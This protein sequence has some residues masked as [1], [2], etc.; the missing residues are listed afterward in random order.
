[1]KPHSTFQAYAMII[2]ILSGFSFHEA[3]LYSITTIM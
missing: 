3:V 1:M 2:D